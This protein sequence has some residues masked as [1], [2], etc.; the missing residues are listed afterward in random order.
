MLQ[1]L[2][3]RRRQNSRRFIVSALPQ[4]MSASNCAEPAAIVHPGRP[5]PVF[6]YRFDREVALI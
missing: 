4:M 2:E 1:R 3:K 5:C 6:T